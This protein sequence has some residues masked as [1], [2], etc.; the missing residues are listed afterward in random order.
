MRLDHKE[1]I[2]RLVIYFFYDADG[3]VDRYVPYMLADIKKNCHELFVVCN[4]KLTP[5]GRAT[6]CAYASDLLVRENQGFDVWAYKTALDHYGW[7]AL[8]KY[9]EIIFMNHTIMG[10]VYPFSEVFAEMDKRD[11]D[12]WG[13]NKYH[14]HNIPAFNLPDGCI[15]EHIQSHFIAVRQSMIKSIK[16]Q[17]YWDNRPPIQNYEDAVGKHE[18][19][20]TK[21]FADRGFR[22]ATYVNTDD[23]EG[24]TPY[25][26]F[27]CPV[28]VIKEYK[29]PVF[30]RRNFFHDYGG[31]LSYSAGR[32]GRELLEFLKSETSYD[33]GMIWEN[34]LRTSNLVDIKENLGLNYVLP[35]KFS[36]VS[37]QNCQTALVLHIYYKDLIPYCLSYAESM[38]DGSDLYITTD[39]ADK[40]QMIEEAI[41]AHKWRNIHVI[42]IKNR[43]RDIS[44]L[45][46]AAAP[47]LKDYDYVCFAHDKKADHE[48]WRLTGFDFSERCFRN[49]LGSK[50]YVENVIALFEKS[51]NLGMMFP[52]PPYHG[53]YFGVSNIPWGMNYKNTKLLAEELGLKVPMSEAKGIIAP[54][55]TM[56]WF[57]PAALQK[58]L[59][60]KWNYSDFPAEPVGVDGTILHAIER[61]Y[62][63]AAQDAGYYSAWVLSDDYAAT[64]WT[65]QTY[66][67][68][69]IAT[70]NMQL[71]GYR[72]YHGLL[73]ML[74]YAICN[75]KQIRRMKG[76]KR[77]RAKELLRKLTPKPVWFL[78][79]K[80]YRIVGGKKWLDETLY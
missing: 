24:V 38:P 75:P 39:A 9:D 50:E 31:R 61:I 19:I 8:A 65:N 47:F 60:R 3:I 15:P 79:K 42:E 46:I 30:K 54:L 69:T 14:R 66:M 74:D 72:S 7:D 64:E 25:P 71:F 10:P 12:F 59:D 29:C 68:Q 49:I 35:S 73:D 22:W 21:Y 48:L 76:S 17:D 41:N 56:F 77:K 70:K 36:P 6:L 78:I 55:G 27:D 40:K 63:L 57:R 18:A 44:A 4:G 32:Q 43:G 67:L 13:L 34:L 1:G 28:R 45:L 80:A 5:D 53:P 26:L 20:F 16:F 62:T 11:L 58:L 33:T 23:M 37:S 2:S 51:P 52:P